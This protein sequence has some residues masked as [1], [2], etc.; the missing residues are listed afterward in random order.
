MKKGLF[1]IIHYTYSDVCGDDY[2]GKEGRCVSSDLVFSTEQQVKKAVSLLNKLNRSYYCHE[3]EDE[4][5]RDC[6]DEDYF[7]YKKVEPTTP[8]T[9]IKHRTYKYRENK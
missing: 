2:Y 5:D 3:P 1:A 7:Y 4:F 6:M 8:I 9:V